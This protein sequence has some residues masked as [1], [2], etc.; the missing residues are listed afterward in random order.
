MWGRFIDEIRGVGVTSLYLISRILHANPSFMHSLPDFL[1]AIREFDWTFWRRVANWRWP[2]DHC[3]V[4][5]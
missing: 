5:E 4:Y 1:T 3:C 2:R